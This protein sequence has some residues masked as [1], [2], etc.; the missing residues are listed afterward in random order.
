MSELLAI[1]PFRLFAIVTVMLV[2]KMAVLGLYTT[3]IRIRRKVFATPEDYTFFGG[4]PRPTAD[5]EIERTRR[6]H[7][8][9]LENIPAFIFVAMI[10]ALT[11]PSMTAAR[12]YFWGFFIARALHS[13]FY[14]RGQQPHRTV[15]FAVGAVL[16][17]LLIV[18]TLVRLL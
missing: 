17:A 15:A 14:V 6:A 12:I 16:M 4:V 18:E 9:D 5:E 13:I 8:N 7:R 2:I 10:Y 11:V 1:P 3:I